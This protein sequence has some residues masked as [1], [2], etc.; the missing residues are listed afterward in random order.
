MKTKLYSLLWLWACSL[1]GSPVF[2]QMATNPIIYA[3]VPDVAIVRVGNN[4]YM[5]STTMHMNPG[6]PIMKSTDLVNWDLVNYCYQSFDNTDSY[7]LNNGKNDYG[8]GSWASSI[9]YHKG[10][11]Y[12]STFANTGKT[13]IYKTANIET[14]PW[15]VSVLPSSYHDCSLFF[16]DDD[17]VYLIYGNG[18]IRIIELN[19]EAT[20]VKA[21]GL[22]KVLIND[23]A[24]VAGSGGLRAEGSQVMK[25]GNYYYV[26]NICWPTGGMRTQVVSRSTSI[27]GTYVSRVALKD[28]GIAQGS[29]I[30]TPTGKWYA[31]LFRDFGSVG[32]VPYLV[33]MTWSSD[34]WPV[35]TSPVP[36]TLDI[37]KG[38]GGLGNLVGSDEFSQAPPLKLAWQWNHNPKNSY[39]SLTQRSGYMRLTNERTDPNVL[40]TTNTL[41]Q[42]TFG[43]KSTAY[44][45]IDVS[46]M[47]DGDYAGMIALQKQYG[48]VGVRMTGGSKSIVMVT[49]DD[50][51]GTPSQKASVP[52]NQTTVYVRVDCDFTNRTDKAYF[53]YSLNGTTWTAIGTTLQMAYTIPQF[54]GYRF[55]L[56]TYA[57][58]SSGGYAD[59]DFYRVGANITE[60]TNSAAQG[61]TV[62]ITS[63]T[64]G[65]SFSTGSAI[66]LAATA[67]ASSGSIAS[68]KFYDG[69][70]L[71]STD[72]TA[73]YTFSWT[74]ATVGS[75][76][77]KAVATDN[78]GKTAEATITI[79]VSFSTGLEDVSSAGIQLYPNPFTSEGLWIRNAGEFSYRITGIGGHL[80]EEGKASDSKSV[81]QGLHPGI[82]FLTIENEKGMFVQ[83]I[84]RQ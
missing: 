11:Y 29:F 22:N 63:P 24:S 54:M 17:R 42:R 20:A 81:G 5:S 83:K 18:T 69:T 3:D 39:W 26:S 60:A 6:V 7:N 16:D 67:V 58:Q 19:A 2:A 32:R 62:S 84:I 49:G 36:T 37:P 64:N 14:G 45:A 8:H 56:F 51:T 53:Y 43:P 10:N 44:T 72:N 75:H 47:K 1:L 59:F 78:G 28:Q 65:A 21:G 66:P 48:Y 25:R 80:Y 35:L 77:I 33:P 34:G 76:D 70:T 71:L 68:V 30:D 79:K 12:V 57:S 46:G 74:D 73:P 41:T 40:M 82:Y 9:R 52:L 38:R 55:G 4:Y 13:Y 61:P 23:P 27:G 31:Y 15:T 50:V